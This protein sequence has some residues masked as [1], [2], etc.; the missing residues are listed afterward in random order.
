MQ[1]S[2]PNQGPVAPAPV[3]IQT[4]PVQQP[5][6]Q[7]V[8]PMMYG[9]P[10]AVSGHS[11]MISQPPGNGMATTSLIMGILAIVCYGLGY[12]IC[13]TWFFGWLF[14]I[15]AIIFGHIG[16]SNGSPTNGG[17]GQALAGLIMGY[18]TIIGYILPFVF[19]GALGGAG[20][21]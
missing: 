9:S 1:P 12:L 14:A 10:Q 11:I 19:L 21:I 8:Q 4:A 6:Q 2:N 7:Q 17:D 13:L 3:Y 16:Y 18:L 20:A 5:I 15:L